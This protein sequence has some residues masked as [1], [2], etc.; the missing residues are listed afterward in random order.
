MFWHDLHQAH[1]RLNSSVVLY[2]KKPVRFAAIEGREVRVK[3]LRTGLHFNVSLE[4][5]KFNNFRDLPKL[6]FV[7]VPRNLFWLT[8]VPAR[9]AT[10]GHTRNNIQVYSLDQGQMYRSEAS[11]EHIITAFG[12]YYADSVTGIFP[13]WQEA[14]R[15]VQTT[16]PIAIHHEFALVRGNDGTVQF[17][18]NKRHVGSVRENGIYLGPSAVYL[19]EELQQRLGIQEIMEA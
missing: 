5:E 2:D 19:R 14:F 3:D 17:W 7:N 6:G 1:Q 8:R 10:H 16:Q 15:H 11:F 9:S 13:T 4:D 18:K 12:K